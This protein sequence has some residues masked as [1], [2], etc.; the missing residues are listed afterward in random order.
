M[1]PLRGT[2]CASPTI[3]LPAERTERTRQGIAGKCSASRT[4]PHPQQ[5]EG[6][7]KLVIEGRM[8]W[9]QRKDTGDLPEASRTGEPGRE[10][11]APLTGRGYATIHRD[12]REQRHKS[13]SLISGQ[14]AIYVGK[15]L[16]NKAGES[17]PNG[18]RL[19]HHT[20]HHTCLTPPSGLPS[21]YHLARDIPNFSHGFSWLVLFSA[22]H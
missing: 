3:P 18:A 16:E 10:R 12:I 4:Y 21:R 8:S 2:A 13:W 1:M 11:E 6:F 5:Q 15:G 22:S 20:P 17:A 7:F 9:R 14:R 19:C